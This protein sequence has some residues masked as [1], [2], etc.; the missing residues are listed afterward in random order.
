MTVSIRLARDADAE[1]MLEIYTPVVRETAI[2]FELEPPTLDE[3]RARVDSTLESMPWLVCASE[4]DVLG[5]AYAGP[6]RSRGAYQWSAEVT[7]YVNAGYRR[8][9]V[10]RAGPDKSGLPGV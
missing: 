2:S 7:V 4:D 3:F 6:Y 9:R 10:G 8:R 5:Y 1:Q